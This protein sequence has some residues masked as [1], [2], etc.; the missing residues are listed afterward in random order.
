M[1]RN[2]NINYAQYIHEFTDANG[3]TRYAVARAENGQYTR[4]VDSRTYKLTGCSQEF[5]HSLKTFGGYLTR[6]EA[7]RRARYLF[8]EQVF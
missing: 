6:R 3:D 7:L 4:P 1:S 5:C 8:S 2:K